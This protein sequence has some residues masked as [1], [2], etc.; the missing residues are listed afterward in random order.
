MTL[1]LLLGAAAFAAAVVLASRNW[2]R[3]QTLV[4]I[5][6][7]PLLAW[8]WYFARLETMSP[9]CRA[10]DECSLDAAL[11]AFAAI[12]VTVGALVGGAVGFW[13]ARER[14]LRAG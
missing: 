1:A 10:D 14:R 5:A 7:M 8:A 3:R 6:L 12:G 9:W 11:V 13:W 2:A 4:A